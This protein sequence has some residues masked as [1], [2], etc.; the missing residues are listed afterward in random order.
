[1]RFQ[2]RLRMAVSGDGVNGG[3]VRGTPDTGGEGSF[4]LWVH[5]GFMVGFE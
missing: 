3:H 4:T 5:G 2:Q 1:M